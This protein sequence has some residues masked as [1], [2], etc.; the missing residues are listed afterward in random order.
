M[1]THNHNT[2]RFAAALALAVAFAAAG[3]QASPSVP[4]DR[5]V[6]TVSTPNAGVV[7]DPALTTFPIEEESKVKATGTAERPNLIARDVSTG[8][9]GGGNCSTWAIIK[10][11]I[12]GVDCRFYMEP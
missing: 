4:V 8:Q 5:S 1:T 10:S 12:F 7:P 11:A 6:A 9:A 2:T 3:I